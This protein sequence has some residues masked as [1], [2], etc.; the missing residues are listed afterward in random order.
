MFAARLFAAQGAVRVENLLA[1]ID[2]ELGC[3]NLFGSLLL[4]ISLGRRVDV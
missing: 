2:A 3:E 1:D 4:A